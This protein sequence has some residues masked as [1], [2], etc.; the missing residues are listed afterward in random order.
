MCRCVASERREREVPAEPI[1]TAVIAE[2]EAKPEETPPITHVADN[3]V[4][5]PD[6]VAESEPVKIQEIT[7]EEKIEPPPSSPATRLGR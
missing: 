6:D 1:I 3:S 4:P 7:A 5:K 2:I